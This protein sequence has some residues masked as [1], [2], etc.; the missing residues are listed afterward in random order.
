MGGILWLCNTWR[1]PL[2]SSPTSIVLQGEKWLGSRHDFYRHSALML[3][4]YAPQKKTSLTLVPTNLSIN[5]S[6]IW[7]L[8]ALGWASPNLNTLSMTDSSVDV[9]S[10]PQKPIQSLTTIP[11]AM[12]S[13]PLLTVPAT[14]GTCRSEDSSSWSSTDVFGWTCIQTHM[15]ST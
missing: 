15:S 6:L 10:I 7:V 12:T 11:A 1:S 4:Q 5:E 14:R 2:K 8:M 3:S 9:V 13:L